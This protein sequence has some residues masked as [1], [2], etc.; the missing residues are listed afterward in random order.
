MSKAVEFI[1]FVRRTPTAFHAVSEISSMLD[2]AGFAQLTETEAWRLAPG[3][4]YYVTRNGSAL[5]AFC[6][7]QR[8]CMEKK[9]ARRYWPRPLF[10]VCGMRQS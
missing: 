1:D 7:P 10:P 2:A 3:G 8:G 9:G 5:I 4:K 6:V